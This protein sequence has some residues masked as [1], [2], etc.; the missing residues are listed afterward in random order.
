[1]MYE[2][3]VYNIFNVNIILF[4]AENKFK[5]MFKI[6]FIRSSYKYCFVK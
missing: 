5:I 1:M 3:D 6:Y 2:V 4:I